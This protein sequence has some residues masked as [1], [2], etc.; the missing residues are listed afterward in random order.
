MTAKINAVPARRGRCIDHG[1]RSAQE[2]RHVGRARFERGS[3]D[4]KSAHPPTQHDLNLSSPKHPKL[5]RSSGINLNGRLARPAG[6]TRTAK[7]KTARV[8]PAPSFVRP[9]RVLAFAHQ[10]RL[11]NRRDLIGLQHPAHAELDVMRVEF[12][13]GV[14]GAR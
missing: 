14:E 11:V 10:W 5:P 13:E 12:A 9:E 4:R 3:E 8:M 2:I 1:A 6:R 7:T